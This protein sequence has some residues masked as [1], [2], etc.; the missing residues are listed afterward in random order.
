VPFDRID[1]A[2]QV[3]AARAFHQHHIARAQILR[4][5]LTGS[6]GIAEKY[7]R[8]AA[9]AG[10]RGQMFRIALDGHDQIETSLGGSASTGDVQRRA[11]LTHL[12][13]FSGHQD[14]AARG[15]PRSQGVDLERSAS[16]F[17]L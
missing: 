7:R 17:E 11:V 4:E 8:H 2:L 6:F 14:A 1:R 5:P 9:G 12:Q 3:H 15:G 16:G 10:R 13:H